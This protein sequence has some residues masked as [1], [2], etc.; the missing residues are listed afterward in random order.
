MAAVGAVIRDH[1][2]EIDVAAGKVFKNCC[3]AEEAEASYCII[4]RC[5]ASHELDQ[6]LIDFLERV[7]TSSKKLMKV[8]YTILFL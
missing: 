1:H 4:R 5:R 3:N 6:K 8:L 7:P 2:T